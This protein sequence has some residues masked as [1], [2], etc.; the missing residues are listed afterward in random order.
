[1]ELQAI[2]KVFNKHSVDYLVIGGD[3]VNIYGGDRVTYDHDVWVNS[4]RDNLERL[5]DALYELEYIKDKNKI[6]VLD[7]IYR[8]VELFKKFKLNKFRLNETDIPLD[9]F[10]SNIRYK[11]FTLCYKRR[12][13]ILIDKVEVNFI[14]KK[15][16]IK[17]KKIAAR[18][19]DLLDIKKI[20]TSPLSLLG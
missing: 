11:K 17:L 19:K 1:M 13:T 4:S 14:S 6:A 10:S 8:P 2:C 16:L 7:R 12:N 20:D 9:I 3:A 5:V 15:D 18:S